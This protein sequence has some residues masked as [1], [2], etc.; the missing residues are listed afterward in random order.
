MALLPFLQRALTALK[1][2][3]PNA[4]H[5]TWP[6]G[7]SGSGDMGPPGEWQ[8]RQRS[9]STD[10]LA[11]FSAVYAC[12]QIISEDLSKLPINFYD[13]LPDGT[14]KINSRY[15]TNALMRKPNPYQN[16]IQFVQNFVVSYLMK[17]NTFV[18][19]RYDNR[20]LV[21]RMD[22][23]DPDKVTMY[24]AQDGSIFY[25]IGIQPLAGINESITVPARYILHHRLIM[26]P[27]YPMVGVTPIYA[28]AA[29]TQNGQ[30]IL[31]NSQQFFGNAARPGGYLTAP[32][33]I[34][35][36]TANR[37]RN[38]WDSSY[39]SG[40]AGKTAVLGEGLE[41]K[42]VTMTYVDSQLIE[43]LRWSIEDVARVFRVPPFMIGD[44]SKTSF[45]NTEQLT[46]TYLNGC[47]SYHIESIEASFDDVFEFD[48]TMETEFDLDELLRSEMDLRYEAYSKAL[49]GGWQT[50]N[51][52]R[53]KEGMQP[54]ENG[55]EPL[56][57]SQ[58]RPLSVVAEMEE[59][60]TVP[61][62]TAGTPS[63]APDQPD[64]TDPADT[65]DDQ[66][67]TSIDAERLRRL[68]NNKLRMKGIAHA[69]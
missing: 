44:L 47:L 39:S 32:Q 46:R 9:F 67:E 18:L 37:L 7:F 59:Q 34:S 43:Q 40:R 5:V 2:S 35:D 60:P 19:L 56:V 54:I 49:L 17:G 52:V 10:A 8:M 66:E 20:N 21:T 64:T 45:R 12:V 65:E 30:Q 38:D 33:R 63:D 58:L 25:K 68:L 14:R 22:I 15:P 11:S 31:S 6:G 51:E 28:A 61:A 27:S 36:E 16:R 53:L 42:P 4:V 55:D 13:L 24:I 23:L 41:F 3:L 62:A 48:G 26:S 69:A 50:I 57:Q 1:K 29:S